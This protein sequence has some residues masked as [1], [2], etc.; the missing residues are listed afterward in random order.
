M[1][2][3]KVFIVFYDDDTL[4]EMFPIITVLQKPTKES[5]NTIVNLLPL[6]GVCPLFW[7]K[8]LM[9]YLSA[10]KDLLIYAPSILVCLF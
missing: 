5:F 7:S 4:G 1:L 2:Y 6:K 10:S 8:A 9:H 3:L